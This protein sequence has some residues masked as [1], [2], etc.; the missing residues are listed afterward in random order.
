M[1]SLKPLVLL[2]FALFT[3]A[4][5]A[6]ESAE[7]TAIVNDINN[8][9]Q[10]YLGQVQDGN[11]PPAEL[12]SLYQQV[13]TYTDDSYTSLYSEVNMG[14]VSS[15]ITGLPWY[16]SRLQ[17]AIESATAG[18]SGG[19]SGGSSASQSSG[20]SGSSESSDSASASSSGGSE[21][22]ASESS[23]SGGSAS[24]SSADS[25]SSSSG[26]GSGGSSSSGGDRSSSATESSSGSGSGGA[27]SGSGSSSSGGSSSSSQSSDSNSGASGFVHDSTNIAYYVVP[28]V[29]ILASPA[30]L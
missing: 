10:D 26:S 21:S 7:L 11:A 12:L 29:M 13:Q 24:S 30:L 23:A 14:D 8:N 16:S 18:G 9:L 27:S 25:A 1:L 6:S 28:L 3:N 19:S 17:P 4:Q 20:G 15:Y 22:S 5:S 2:A